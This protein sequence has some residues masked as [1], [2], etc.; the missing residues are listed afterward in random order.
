MKPVTFGFM[1]GK[2]ALSAQIVSYIPAH[3]CW[4]EPFC[5]SAIVTLLKQPSPV[6]VINDINSDITNFFQQLRDNPEE[7]TRKL[8]LIPYSRELYDK[9]NSDWRKHQWPEDKT[10]RAACW[11]YLQESS[12]SGKF[13]KGWS[14]SSKANAATGFNTK[15]S[16]LKDTA[17]RLK[18]V[19]IE[20]SDALEVIQIYDSPQTA[21][22]VDPP[23]ILQGDYYYSLKTFDHYKLH[24]ALNKVRGK[25]MLSYYP[26]SGLDNLYLGWH[27]ISLAASKSSALVRG[28]SK[29]PATELILCNYEMMPLFREQHEP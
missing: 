2:Q 28:T 22:Y 16:Q 15:V 23:Y 4:V 17:R 13:G 18:D 10:E 6:E 24:D 9:Y 3:H 12:F 26:H 8:D 7:L 19:L 1:G 20:N 27:K 25:V 21:F 11:F 14:H 5:G 29:P